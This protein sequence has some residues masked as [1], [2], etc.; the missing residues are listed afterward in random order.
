MQIL[1]GFI[2]LKDGVIGDASLHRKGRLLC[3]FW[4][5]TFSS[6]YASVLL[7][8]PWINEERNSQDADSTTLWNGYEHYNLLFDNFSSPK[9]YDTNYQV[10]RYIWY[11]MSQIYIKNQI[12][13]EEIKIW[14]I[15]QWSIS[16]L[17]NTKMSWIW[18]I[19]TKYLVFHL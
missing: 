17:Y 12:N 18:L 8:N 1:K 4:R 2:L 10:A 9:L 6:K 11:Y 14:Y 16:V 3:L 7:S 5:T 19:F 13:V 15:M